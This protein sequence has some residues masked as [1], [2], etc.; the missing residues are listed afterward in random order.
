[1]DLKEFDYLLYYISRSKN[2]ECK[3]LKLKDNCS[4][5][6]TT[7]RTQTRNSTEL[8]HGTSAFK[9]HKLINNTQTNY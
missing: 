2:R 4:E 3:A 8:Y 1:M 6:V 7:N 9:N 5:P